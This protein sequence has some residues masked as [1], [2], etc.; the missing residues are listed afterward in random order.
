MYATIVLA[1]DG[2][3]HAQNALKSAAKLAQTFGA[4]LH[5]A[6]TPQV[7]TPPLVIGSYM[8]PLHSPP[9]QE[10]IEEAGEHIATKAHAEAKAADVEI[11]QV[12]LGVG[13]PGYWILDVAE[14]TNADLIVMGRRGL[15]AFRA[16]ALGSVS[17]D[18]AQRAKCACLTVL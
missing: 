6:H 9:T 4:T 8:G 2:S 5:M 7:D 17:Q 1:Y 10:Q 15:G 18:V 11:A 12:H 13:D 16:L 14:K 3:E